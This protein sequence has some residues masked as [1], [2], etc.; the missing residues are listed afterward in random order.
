[1]PKV[2]A[3]RKKGISGIAERVHG[4]H[5]VGLGMELGIWI[6]REGLPTI[7][8][9]QNRCECGRA[10]AYRYRRAMQDLLAREALREPQQAAA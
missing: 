6:L 8:Q 9:I 5:Q 2:V 7:E 10:T 1:M 4:A 3:P